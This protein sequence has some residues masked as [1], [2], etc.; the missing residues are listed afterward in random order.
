MPFATIK[1]ELFC[2]NKLLPSLKITFCLYIKYWGGG[3]V[4]STVA[5]HLQG[6]EFEFHPLS[7][8]VGF[9]NS[10]HVG[11]VSS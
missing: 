2:S 3:R 1:I 5:S 8:C 9:L 11:Q 10:P 6:M 4:S 7:E